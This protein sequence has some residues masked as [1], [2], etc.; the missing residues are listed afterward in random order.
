MRNNRMAVGVRLAGVASLALM[1]TVGAGSA[2]DGLEGTK[3]DFSNQDWFDGDACGVCHTPQSSGPPAVVPLWNPRA[4][5]TKSF[6]P[7]RGARGNLP[8]QGTLSC[9]RCHDGTVAKATIGGANKPRFAN[10]F[11][12][13]FFRSGHGTSD[14]PVGIPYPN[15]AKGFRPMTTVVAGG[16]VTLPAGNVECV[17]CHDPH[18]Q[19]GEKYMLVSTNARSALCLTCHAK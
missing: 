4:D 17:S 15:V 5:V 14:H 6:A 10:K 11:N 12:P 16:A 1:L 8:G 3:H 2:Q 9:L 19:S 7:L 13:G 18:G